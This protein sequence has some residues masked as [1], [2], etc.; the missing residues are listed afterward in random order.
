MKLHTLLFG[1][2]LSVSLNAVADLPLTQADLLG[3]W[4][5]EKEAA[6]AEGNNARTS[7]AVWIFKADGTMEGLAEDND[8][9][10]RINQMRAVLN[11][12][13]DNGKL[14]KQS[15]PG[16]PKM[17][18]CVALEKDG[19]KMVLKCSTVYYFMSKK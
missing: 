5:I 19:S 10:A 4:Q 7:N 6:N 9:N 14:S 1:A 13:V 18:T 2:L 3:T 12:T 16:R 11:Y 15:G 8:K 17:E